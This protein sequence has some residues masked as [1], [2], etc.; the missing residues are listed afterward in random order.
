MK[1]VRI[2]GKKYKYETDVSKIKFKDFKD[3]FIKLLEVQKESLNSTVYDKFSM[4]SAILGC[5]YDEAMDAPAHIFDDLSFWVDFELIKQPV[6]KQI[7]LTSLFGLKSKKVNI[8]EKLTNLSLSTGQMEF[9]RQFYINARN[10]YS[11]PSMEETIQKI[12]TGKESELTIEDVDKWNKFTLDMHSE[13]I[14]NADILVSC[15]LQTDVY[16]NFRP[17]KNVEFSEKLA[18]LSFTQLVPIAFF[19]NQKLMKYWNDRQNS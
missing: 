17:K 4:I 11:Y 8:P 14:K 2:N 12:T 3:K 16:G 15:I 7:D 13:T 18:D 1:S 19:L 5:E 9:F 10:Q 6:P